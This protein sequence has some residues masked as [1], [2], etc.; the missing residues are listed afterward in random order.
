MEEKETRAWR[1]RLRR[2]AAEE[3]E[4]GARLGVMETRGCRHDAREAQRLAARWCKGR[5]GV[6][7]A[8]SASMMADD[9]V[10]AKEE[11]G[12]DG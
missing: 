6:G 5:E 9:E 12:D 8:G 7:S 2:L 3:G 1:K 4:G 11:K 10:P